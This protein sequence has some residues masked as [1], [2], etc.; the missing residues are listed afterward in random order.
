M[1]KLVQIGSKTYEIPEQGDKAGW[2]EETTAWMEGVT[3]ALG[4]VQGTNDILVTSA[5][6]A[7]N[8][9]AASDIPGLLFNVAQVESV[10]IDYIIK[11][12][13]DLGT[14]TVVETGKI[15]AVYDG[16]EFFMSTETSGETGTTI[17]V[18]NSGQF[19]YTTTDLTDHQSSIIRFRAKTIDTP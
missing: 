7:N 14:S 10:E 1:S 15:L 17:S 5:T 12:V 3:D 8:Q 6:L 4:N 11:R 19:Q 16:S 9:A 18:L 13:Y 2:G